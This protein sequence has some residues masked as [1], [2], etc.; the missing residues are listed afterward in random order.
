MNIVFRNGHVS[1]QNLLHCLITYVQVSMKCKV[2][3]FKEHDEVT[4][5]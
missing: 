5:L 3:G 4:R 2:R 1:N